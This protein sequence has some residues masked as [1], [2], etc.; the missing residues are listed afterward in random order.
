MSVIEKEVNNFVEK[1][2]QNDFITEISLPVTP[3]LQ[4]SVAPQEVDG[5]VQFSA[6]QE[7]FHVKRDFPMPL[8][9]SF[10]CK[11]H[12]YSMYPQA[13]ETCNSIYNMKQDYLNNTLYKQ[14]F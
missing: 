13:F 5:S 12:F 10:Q 1:W 8:K 7:T 6:K 11:W 3:D 4:M 2:G 14:D 9:F